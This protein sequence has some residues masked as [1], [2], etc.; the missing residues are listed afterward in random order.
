[1]CNVVLV[2]LCNGVDIT[3]AK[4]IQ[5]LNGADADA[6]AHARTHTH[7]RNSVKPLVNNRNQSDVIVLGV[8]WKR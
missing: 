6:D 1:M 3:A 5:S 2:G 8:A 4:I 7:A